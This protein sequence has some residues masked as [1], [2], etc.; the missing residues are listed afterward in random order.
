MKRQPILRS[1]RRHGYM[2]DYY[3]TDKYIPDAELI[4]NLKVVMDDNPDLWT[5]T[6]LDAMDKILSE[7]GLRVL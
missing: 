6:F 1:D 7:K 2:V 4:A 3:P 5:R